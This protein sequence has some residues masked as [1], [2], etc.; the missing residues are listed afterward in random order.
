MDLGRDWMWT[1]GR[2]MRFGLE[3]R[4]VL[5]LLG[6]DYSGDWSGEWVSDG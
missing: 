5:M 1:P 6:S 3:G 2:Y 4:G